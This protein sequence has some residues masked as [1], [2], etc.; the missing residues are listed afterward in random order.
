MEETRKYAYVVT[1]EDAGDAEHAIPR[2]VYP[3]RLLAGI[4]V[5]NWIDRGRHATLSLW[6]VILASA[7]PANFL[8]TLKSIDSDELIVI[9]LGQGAPVIEGFSA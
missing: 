3:S 5:K 7:D 4:A 9:R 8:L 1:V 6:H 2:E